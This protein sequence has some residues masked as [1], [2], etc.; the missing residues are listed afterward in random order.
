MGLK[1][2]DVLIS[3][4]GVRFPEVYAQIENLHVGM[5]GTCVA[6][7]KIQTSREAMTEKSALD[8]LAVR[9]PVDK[10]LPIYKQAYEYAKREVFP[11]WEDDIPVEEVQ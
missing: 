1:K 9:M 8:T 5:D 2:K 11:D 4:L 10:N 3:S 7:F 6:R